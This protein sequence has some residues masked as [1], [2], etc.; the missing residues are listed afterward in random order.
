MKEDSVN[1]AEKI[2]KLIND[3]VSANQIKS[4]LVNKPEYGAAVG[5]AIRAKGNL[6][7]EIVSLCTEYDM[8]KREHERTSRALTDKLWENG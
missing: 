2:L 5:D 8:L 3:L 4:M 7:A 1:R 6:E